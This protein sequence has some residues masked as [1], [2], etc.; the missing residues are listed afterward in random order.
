MKLRNHDHLT[1]TED[2]N[3]TAVLVDTRSGRRWKLDA[4][5][6]IVVRALLDGG[7][8]DDAARRLTESLR[9]TFERATADATALIETMRSAGA[10]TT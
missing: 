10:E 6:A 2:D 8:L 1:V 9:V 7:E 5:G 4:S 3:G